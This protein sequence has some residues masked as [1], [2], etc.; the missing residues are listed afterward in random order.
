MGCAF[1]NDDVSGGGGTWGWRA[2]SNP[3][4]SKLGVAKRCLHAIIAQLGEGDRLS[5]VL[6]NHS[7]KVLLP[8]SPVG[9]MSKTRMKKLTVQ[10]DQLQ[11]GGGT[12]LSEGFEAGMDI[13]NC[14]DVLEA[15]DAAQ[16]RVIFLTDMESGPTDEKA[17]VDSARE[18]ASNPARRF[19][20]SIV[21][22]GVDLS[23]GTVEDLSSIPGC[24]YSS[25]ASAAEF[26]SSV[27]TEFAYDV[28]PIAFDI[29]IELAPSASAVHADGDTEQLKG[30]SVMKGFGSPE[31]HQLGSSKGGSGGK[32]TKGSD[33]GIVKLSCEFA[34]PMTNESDE[35][36]NSDTK[37]S[38]D[39]NDAMDVDIEDGVEDDG[40]DEDDV[41]GATGGLLGALG[42]GV[43]QLRG[44]F[45]WGASGT[46][47]GGSSDSEGEEAATNEYAFD[48]SGM[49]AGG[50]LLF[51]LSPPSG[52]S[53]EL[54]TLTTRVVT[55]WTDCN[56]MPQEHEQT[57][58][59]SFDKAAAAADTR[60]ATRSTATNA[61]TAASSSWFSCEAIR[62]ALALVGYV[63]LQSEYILDD[64][65]PDEGENDV[66]GK[67]SDEQARARMT[68]FTG[69]L[70]RH[71][72][73]ER[74]FRDLH[75]HLLHEIGSVLGDRSLV[76]QKKDPGSG[77]NQS[78]M[79]TIEQILEMETKAITKTKDLQA[80]LQAQLE[81]QNASNGGNG[82]SGKEAR[83]K[84]KQ[85]DTGTT[86]NGGAVPNEYLCPIGGELMTDPV[87]AADG[88][89]YE[90]KAISQWIHQS[91][92]QPAPARRGN[93]RARNAVAVRSPMTNQ[94][95][96]S[97][98]LTANV[99]L[100]KIIQDYSAQAP[101]HTAAGGTRSSVTAAAKGGKG[102]KSRRR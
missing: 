56:G 94:P 23:V 31:L 20:T 75:S 67:L 61:S 72:Q 44:L 14:T 77:S 24:K 41:T 71:I 87:I 37:G 97:T 76:E 52:N 65:D 102:K 79:Q 51:E 25:V 64:D 78:I 73:Y 16:R 80:Q 40:A 50:I 63:D 17:V 48:G 53:E 99:T 84:R 7:Q 85:E 3:E 89:S 27:A 28:T 39:T 69:W 88:H 83:N 101:T 98:Q 93:Q 11:P 38:S 60:S 21:G 35:K 9:A 46:V 12:N 2:S 96:S 5:I 57:I 30:L 6:F 95:L 45:G 32:N 19:H 59:F 4:N 1:D 49:V 22:V 26:E 33:D 91:K 81:R 62:K 8:L 36:G 74:R 68:K 43:E 34:A 47:A 29:Q 86:G 42:Q 66:M 55:R 90:R 15:S 70:A 18:N 82:G 10:I 54:R 92:Q 13:L 58:R 100:R